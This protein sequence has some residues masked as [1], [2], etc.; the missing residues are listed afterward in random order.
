[1]VDVTQILHAEPSVGRLHNRLTHS[2]K[3]AQIAR[4]VAERFDDALFADPDVCEAAGLAHDLGHPR[5]GHLGE[6]TLDEELVQRGL[7]GYEGN[8]QAFRVLTKL[9]VHNPIRPGLNLTRAT[10]NATLKYPFVRSD[11]AAGGARGVY[12]SE[13]DQFEFA[14]DG[15]GPLPGAETAIVE[16]ADDIS[17][18]LHGFD[19]FYRA[20]LVRLDEFLDADIDALAQEVTRRGE[21]GSFDSKLWRPAFENLRVAFSAP[22]NAPL[23]SNFSGD[24]LQQGILRAVTS[25]LITEWLDSADRRSNEFVVD[26]VV[27]HQVLLIKEF[28][29]QRVIVRRM[30]TARSQQRERLRLQRLFSAIEEWIRRE[31]WER[32]PGGLRIALSVS[33]TDAEDP[34]FDAVGPRGVADFISQMTESEAEHRERQ[35]V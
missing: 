30:E 27:Q 33:L 25:R 14:T 16:W 31:T 18:A 1:L 28:V 2:L 7:C 21:P 20:G 12:P 6:A 9:A 29:Y 34:D 26:P 15:V 13:R 23:L 10:L 19:D 24:R 35:L 4:S 3:V 17:Y 5:Y 8:A 11:A 32:L 22:E